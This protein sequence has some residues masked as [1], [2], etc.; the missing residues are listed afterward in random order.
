M[1]QRTYAL[2]IFDLDG[3]LFRGDSPIPGAAAAIERLRARGSLIRYFTNNSSLTREAYV[4][5]L[6]RL[7]FTAEPEEVYSSAIGASAHL[8][9]RNCRR[10]FVVGEPGLN[11][12]LRRDGLTPVDEGADAVLVGI[13]KS[14]SYDLLNGAMQQILQGASFFA[15]NTDATYPMEGGRTIPGAG[16]LVAAVQTCSGR[17]PEVIGKPSPLMVHQ[18]LRDAG[19]DRLDA[20]M[21]G[22]R[23]ETDIEAGLRAG[24][25]SLLVLTGVTQEPPPGV[26]TL[27]SVADLAN[28]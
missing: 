27:P 5:K 6:R 2:T 22:D 8:R 14:F 20:L 13:C 23:Y 7:G 25:D 19:V 24:C 3:T 11:E 28:D 18:I 17:E 15:T 16:S 9:E 12:T 26:W 4:E 1:P 21:V 10:I